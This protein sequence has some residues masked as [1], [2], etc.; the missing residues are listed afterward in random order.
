MRT[1]RDGRRVFRVVILS[2]LVLL[3]PSV[4]SAQARARKASRLAQPATSNTSIQP[5]LL[6]ADTQPTLRFPV[7]RASNTISYGWLDISR[8]G[9]RYTV[10]QPAQKAADGFN[11]SPAKIH[12]LKLE[13]RNNTVT[14][15]N[16][17]KRETVFYVPQGNWGTAHGGRA[18][19]GLTAEGASGTQS[20][21]KTLLDFDAML[22]L[23][24]STSAPAAAMVATPVVQPPPPAP[25]APP[26]PPAI[27]VASPTGASANQTVELQES[28]LVIRG[29]AMDSSGIPVVAINGSPASMRPQTTQAAEFWSDPLPLHPGDN[30][31]QI[32]AVNAAH[33]ETKLAFTIHYTPKAAPANPKALAKAEVISLL[34]GAVPAARVAGI[35]KERGIKFTPT[36][37]DLKEIRDAGGDDDLIQAIQ[38]AAPPVH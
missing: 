5:Q 10:V 19:F 26:S 22:A 1:T 8:Q 11:A 27:I 23:V 12:D 28:P 2:L 21:Y 17:S 34:Q 15:R 32:S 24:K 33:V 4:A 13:D 31:F 20:I 30:P 14:F 29:V 18:F 6:N 36:P 7:A 38:Q 9:V 25:A 3:L 37:D 16:G 35:V